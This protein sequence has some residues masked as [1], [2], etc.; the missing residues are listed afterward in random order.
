M[1]AYFSIIEGGYQEAFEDT[2]AEVYDKL[3]GEAEDSYIDPTS[4]QAF[5][6]LVGNDEKYGNLRDYLTDALV[7]IKEHNEGD[8]DATDLNNRASVAYNGIYSWFFN[9]STRDL[10]Q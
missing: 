2:F 1:D 4:V 10:T 7:V 5:L 9:L 3:N 8:Y 6:Q